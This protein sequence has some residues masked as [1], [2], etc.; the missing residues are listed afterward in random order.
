ME[1]LKL[2][3]MN[4][5]GEISKIIWTL[6]KQNELLHIINYIAEDKPN[7]S[8]KFALELKKSIL[9]FLYKIEV[10]WDFID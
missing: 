2:Y 7:A 6:L 5:F 3:R 8:I 4:H 9:T 1:T 10:E